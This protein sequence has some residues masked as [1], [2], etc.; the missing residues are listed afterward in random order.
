[1]AYPE[2]KIRN[3]NALLLQFEKQ[4]LNISAMMYGYCPGAICDHIP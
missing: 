3:A 1:M 4:W 2:T